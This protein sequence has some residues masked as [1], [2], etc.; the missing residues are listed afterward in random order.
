MGDDG[1]AREAGGDLGAGVVNNWGP[2]DPLPLEAVA[3]LSAAV[4]PET[5]EEAYLRAESAVFSSNLIEVLKRAT[6]RRGMSERDRNIATRRLLWK[7]ETQPTF[8]QIGEE[9]S[10][11]VERVRQ[12][13]WV[14]RHYLSFELQRNERT[15]TETTPELNYIPS[16][17]DPDII[18]RADTPMGK[19]LST[20]L[21]AMNKVLQGRKPRG[22][23]E[24][25]VD[26][27]VYLAIAAEVGADARTYSRG[28]F[29]FTKD[30]VAVNM[31][32]RGGLR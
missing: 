5:P 11:S 13:C 31:V 3:E 2:A 28:V 20:A 4:G 8:R 1:F 9:F 21:L 15:S 6:S 7:G 18:E 27:E 26:Q 22:Y 30:G 17:I 19:P 12:I 29:T 14:A 16:R 32:V 23:V 25:I 10:L 24:V